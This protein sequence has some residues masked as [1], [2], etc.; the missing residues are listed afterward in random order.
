MKK[1]M[2]KSAKQRFAFRKTGPH[3][4]NGS[5]VAVGNVCVVAEMEEFVVRVFKNGKVTVSKHLRILYDVSDGNYV[6]LALV[7][8]YD[9]YWNDPRTYTPSP[10]EAKMV[11]YE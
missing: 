1:E 3:C 8:F 9:R 11:S 4:F 10:S 6:R 5:A 2:R 7:E